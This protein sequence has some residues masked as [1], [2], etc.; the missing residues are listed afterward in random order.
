MPSAVKEALAQAKSGDGALAEWLAHK[1]A[2]MRTGACFGLMRGHPERLSNEVVGWF[3]GIGMFSDDLQSIARVIKRERHTGCGP[4]IVD[5]F[6]AG[7]LADVPLMKRQWKS[8]E[9]IVD[10]IGEVPASL[11]EVLP[12][13]LQ[14]DRSLPRGVALRLAQRRGADAIPTI[15]AA[16][17][18]AEGKARK[19]LTEAL[20][21]LRPSKLKSAS[22]E[23]A[24]ELLP[25]LIEAWS[26]SRHDALGDTIV[27]LGQSLKRPALSAK[28]KGELEA[29]WLA[30]AAQRDPGDVNR[31]L[32]TPWPGAWKTALTRVNALAA[33]PSDP[34]VSRGLAEAALKYRSM[35]SA[36]LHR[37][38]AV[39]LS[40]VADPGSADAIKQ[41]VATR[42]HNKDDYQRALN[43]IARVVKAP[44]AAPSA[45]LLD[46]VASL[47]DASTDVDALWNAVWDDPADLGARLVL[48]DALQQNGD[49]RGEFIS[50]Q[51]IDDPPRKT[52]TRANKLLKANIDPWTGPLPAV[53]RA[54]RVF[55]RGFLTRLRITASGKEV[56]AALKHK[57]WRTV[58][59]LTVDRWRS[60]NIGPLLSR[61][62][63]LRAFYARVESLDAIAKHG[64]FPSVRVL[65]VLPEPV[66]EPL[67]AF[68]HLEVLAGTWLDWN[69][70]VKKCRAVLQQPK[71]LGL[72]GLVVRHLRVGIFNQPEWTIFYRNYRALSPAGTVSLE[73]TGDGKWRLRAPGWRI[74]LTPEDVTVGWHGGGKWNPKMPRALLAPFQDITSKRVCVPVRGKTGA[75]ALE[76]LKKDLPAGVEIVSEPLKLLID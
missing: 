14:S 57:E 5:A 25:V 30:L 22:A 21:T 24:A 8:I 64:P 3:V 63:S 33:F 75:A 26:E 39:V 40:R 71:R 1:E 38:L 67:S 7:V 65:G 62:P 19:R 31:L 28:S 72:R 41:I 51:C 68:P 4:F 9:T 34:R 23:P 47:L 61:M 35:G 70:T 17:A 48:A 6:V 52:T 20:A 69:L 13:G 36:P 74:H 55:E 46:Q 73:M 18:G 32:D 37:A 66:R 76:Q 44:R 59:E 12:I 54:S 29:A 15:E 27:S 16:V 58:E 53:E 49:P 2:Y 10:R 11:I 43:A 60:D 56:A 50:L 45:E 42:Y